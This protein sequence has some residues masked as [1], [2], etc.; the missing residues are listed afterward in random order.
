[1]IR[2][3][4]KVKLQKIEISACLTYQLIGQDSCRLSVRVIVAE[5]YPKPKIKNIRWMMTFQDSLEMIATDSDITGQTL[6][7]MLLLMIRD[8][9]LLKFNQCAEI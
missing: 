1:M 3:P 2:F 9:R 5:H 6:K 7:V 4:G 8:V